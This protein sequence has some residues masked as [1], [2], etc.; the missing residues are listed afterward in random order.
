MQRHSVSSSSIASIGYESVAQ[1]LEV[2]FLGGRV[3]Q[4][5]GVPE[6]L[7]GEMMQAPSAGRFFHVYIR[8]GY[9]YSRV[10]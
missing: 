7:F 9:P 3:Y 1:T 10:S 8:N 4:Y 2:E 6:P 5:Y